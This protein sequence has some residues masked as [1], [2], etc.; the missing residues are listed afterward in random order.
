MIRHD[1]CVLHA[2]MQP[3]NHATMQPCN[4]RRHW[5]AYIQIFFQVGIIAT[6]NYTFFNM[7]T[8][9]LCFPLF[10]DEWWSPPPSSSSSSSSTL[11]AAPQDGGRFRV[12][13]VFTDVLLKRVDVNTSIFAFCAMCAGIVY[14]CMEMFSVKHSKGTASGGSGAADELFSI[15]NYMLQLDFGIDRV[16]GLVNA[17]TPMAVTFVYGIAMW[18]GALDVC[19]HI[20]EA[21]WTSRSR[22]QQQANTTDGGADDGGAGVVNGSG[23][24]S[25]ISTRKQ[26]NRKTR[27]KGDK[28]IDGETEHN[29]VPATPMSTTVVAA[30]QKTTPKQ[31]SSRSA[32]LFY[33]AQLVVTTAAGCA[34]ILVSSVPLA[35]QL[36]VG[37]PDVYVGECVG[38][39]LACS[40]RAGDRGLRITLVYV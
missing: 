20:S 27:R 38:G 6:G 31:S 23:G 13:P 35:Q 25:T 19:T 22:P 36:R 37:L 2:T 21:I 15:D 12:K 39:A 40:N 9:V 11:G 16:N 4:H 7:L 24:G 1:V 3:C 29:A 8:I 18:V 34:M 10:D 28:K 26:A 17:A 5:A 14:A 30:S 33:A 32:S